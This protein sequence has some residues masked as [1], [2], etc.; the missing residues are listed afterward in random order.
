ME[1]HA[2]GKIAK[3]QFVIPKYVNEV[4]ISD[5]LKKM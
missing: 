1:G 5:L 4:G 3:H 2:T